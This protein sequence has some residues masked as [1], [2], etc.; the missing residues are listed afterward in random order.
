MP[1]AKAI[2]SHRPMSSAH[3]A[4]LARG[5]EEGRAVRRYLEAIEHNRLRR[6]RKRTPDSIRKRLGVVNDLLPSSD[7]LARLHLLQEKADLTAELARSSSTDDLAMLEKAFVKVAKAY[8]L[9]KGIGYNAWRAAGVSAAVL[10][11]AEIGRAP[12]G[13]TTA[14]PI[15]PMT[16]SKTRTRTA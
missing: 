3:K 4:A 1:D 15:S 8:G 11:R 12:N 6:G 10:Q 9:R 5:R 14:T 13:T 7:P 16:G 2:P